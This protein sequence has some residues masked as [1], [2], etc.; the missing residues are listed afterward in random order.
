MRRNAKASERDKHVVLWHCQGKFSGL[1]QILGRTSEL[2]E[3]MQMKTFPEFVPD[4][5]FIDH[6]G[7]ASLHRIRTR[8]VEYKENMPP[9]ESR[10]HPAL[11][12]PDYVR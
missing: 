11:E 12:R 6:K 3:K 10:E 7:T 5:D 9:S 2:L 4:V 8:Y 1:W